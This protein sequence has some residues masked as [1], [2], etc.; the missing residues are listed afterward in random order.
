ML[1]LTQI[2]ACISFP[3]HAVM[4]KPWLVFEQLVY[5]TANDNQQ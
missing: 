3:Q 4:Q 1:Q 5:V 2:L